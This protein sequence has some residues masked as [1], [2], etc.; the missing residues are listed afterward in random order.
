MNKR[1][2]FGPLQ[3]CLFLVLV[4]SSFL[5]LTVIETCHIPL[6]NYNFIVFRVRFS[7]LLPVPGSSQIF[8]SWKNELD[9]DQVPCFWSLLSCPLTITSVIGKK[10]K[11]SPARSGFESVTVPIQNTYFMNNSTVRLMLSFRTK[12]EDYCVMPLHYPTFIAYLR[13]I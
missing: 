2:R 7:Y 4:M 6:P 10:K 1:T 9:F 3:V 12:L 5:L 8:Q 11:K 13:Y